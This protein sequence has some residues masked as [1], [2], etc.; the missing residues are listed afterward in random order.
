MPGFLFELLKISH[1]VALPSLRVLGAVRHA[2]GHGVTQLLRS[3]Q[4][5]LPN[6]SRRGLDATEEFNNTE[7]M[8]EWFVSGK[9]AINAFSPLSHAD[10][11]KKQQGAQRS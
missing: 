5:Q 6:G 1:L 3:N 8:Q 2:A 11:K 7:K 10:T 9:N 4:H